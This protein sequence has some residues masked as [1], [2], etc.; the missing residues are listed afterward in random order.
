M[1][2]DDDVAASA[3]EH[4]STVWHALVCQARDGLSA[5]PKARTESLA[6]SGA[7]MPECATRASLCLAHRNPPKRRAVPLAPP[8]PSS[9]PR[10]QPTPRAASEPTADVSPKSCQ[11][12]S[13]GRRKPTAVKD[14][15]PPPQEGRARVGT[16]HSERSRGIYKTWNATKPPYRH[17]GFPRKWE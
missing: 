7:T 15:I 17:T 2:S 16:C 13:S 5:P 10:R 6:R 3:G 14:K 4:G 8:H 9:K 12:E 11:P 1:A